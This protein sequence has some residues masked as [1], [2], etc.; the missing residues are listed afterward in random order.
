M[1]S[2]NKTGQTGSRFSDPGMPGAINKYAV[3]SVL[4]ALGYAYGHVLT[5]ELPV[6]SLYSN[7]QQKP[8]I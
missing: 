6:K 5:P 7:M 3:R 8:M 4:E 2:A 1:E